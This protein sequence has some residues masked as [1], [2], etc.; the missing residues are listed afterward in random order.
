L[1]TLFSVGF[2]LEFCEECILEAGEVELV[3]L[4]LEFAE[5]SLVEIHVPHFSVDLRDLYYFRFYFGLE[6]V[7]H[8]HE[9][10]KI[11]RFRWG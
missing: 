7:V 4:V 9:F 8:E 6:H 2:Q 11:R 5:E 1:L 3:E 10:V